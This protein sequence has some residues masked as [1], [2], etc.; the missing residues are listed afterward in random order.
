MSCRNYFL[1]WKNK[2]TLTESFH[3]S[4][5]GNPNWSTGPILDT[6]S[7]KIMQEMGLE[8]TRSCD[9]RHLKPARLPIPPLLHFLSCGSHVPFNKTYHYQM[10][11]NLST[12]FFKFFQKISNFLFC[13]EKPAIRRLFGR[14]C[15]TWTPGRKL[16]SAAQVRRKYRNQK[17]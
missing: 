6:Q 5:Q 1:F 8:P 14:S 15:I 4:H 2:N 12:A 11:P 9:H 17:H 13:P 7:E 16:P 10:I 3:T